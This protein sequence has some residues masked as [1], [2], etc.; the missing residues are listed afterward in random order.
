MAALHVVLV[1]ALLTWSVRVSPLA[2][3]DNAFTIDFVQTRPQIPDRLV[4]IPL[5]MVAPKPADRVA[6]P[7]IEI[8]SAALTATPQGAMPAKPGSDGTGATGAGG[9]G[10]PDATGENDGGYSEKVRKHVFSFTGDIH[11]EGTVVLRFSVDKQGKLLSYEIL[12][13]SGDY[14]VD[15]AALQMLRR[16]LPLPA[17]PETLNVPGLRI[18][19]PI[20]Y[21]R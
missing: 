15:E 9:G 14:R 12:K 3:R 10:M 8:A 17:M 11:I 18:T 21:K 5:N 16:A 4:S 20:K 1:V 7:S 13:P 19:M 2:S 6:L